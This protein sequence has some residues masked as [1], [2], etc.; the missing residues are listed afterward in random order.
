M[1][2]IRCIVLLLIF[3]GSARVYNTP[4]GIARRCH[5]TPNGEYR[6]HNMY[7]GRTTYTVNCGVMKPCKTSREKNIYNI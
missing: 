3:T 2:V 1:Y 4:A 6:A 5:R 7:G